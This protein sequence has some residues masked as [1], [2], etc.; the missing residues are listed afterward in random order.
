V[1]AVTPG[2]ECPLWHKFLGKVTGGDAELKAYLQRVAGYCCTGFVREQALF[3]LY[4]TGANG[5]GVFTSTL[6][7]VLG[8]Y[9]T[10]APLDTR[11]PRCGPCG[12]VRG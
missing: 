7:G 12:L 5:K 3:F 11:R 9:A 2:G 1:T 4:G 6:A 8:D 10:T